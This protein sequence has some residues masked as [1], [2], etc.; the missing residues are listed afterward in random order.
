MKASAI[1]IVA[2]AAV[3]GVV[4]LLTDCL[5]EGQTLATADGRQVPMKCHW[6]AIAEFALAVPL[7]GVG[8]SLWF[9]RRKETRRPLALL[10]MIIGALVILLPTA[11]IG[12][13]QHPDA[14]CNLVMRP[15]LILSGTLVMGISMLSLVVSERRAEQ[16][17]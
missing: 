13:C 17:A 5:A 12:V 9:S 2:L 3:V 16:I 8:A 14:T 1:L 10:G 6:T 4:P 15:T 7:L 11:L